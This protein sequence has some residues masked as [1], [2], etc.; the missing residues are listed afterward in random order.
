MGV[1]LG[2]SLW[3]E[4]PP[5]RF[6]PKMYGRIKLGMT[7]EEVQEILGVPGGDHAT[8][9]EAIVETFHPR[10]GA[11]ASYTSKGFIWKDTTTR[12]WKGDYGEVTVL[13]GGEGTVIKKNWTNVALPHGDSLLKRIAIKLGVTGGRREIR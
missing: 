4:A 11:W 1:W 5:Q 9:P 2:L 7:Y 10:H 8:D 6:T 12:R 3:A 13:F